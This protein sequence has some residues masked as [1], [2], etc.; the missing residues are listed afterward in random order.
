[1]VIS[2]MCDTYIT[3]RHFHEIIKKKKIQTQINSMSFTKIFN[4]KIFFINFRN[5]LQNIFIFN[6]HIALNLT[7]KTVIAN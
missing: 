2:D 3:I 5:I 7:V 4:K 6:K 1:M